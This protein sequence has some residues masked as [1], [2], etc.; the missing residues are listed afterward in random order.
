MHVGRNMS[1]S[2]QS[3]RHKQIY[4]EVFHCNK[5]AYVD[6]LHSPLVDAYECLGLS[7]EFSLEL[8][9]THSL[10]NLNVNQSPAC[11]I[12]MRDIVTATMGI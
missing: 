12:T 9:R 4:Y 2:K 6:V 11:V 3:T 1:W 8:G 10:G 7:D 5:N